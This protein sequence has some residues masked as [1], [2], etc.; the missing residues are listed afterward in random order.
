MRLVSHP[1]QKLVRVKK[2]QTSPLKMA[3]AKIQ[4]SEQYFSLTD[5][6]VAQEKRNFLS[7][8]TVTLDRSI[9]LSHILLG[10]KQDDGRV[11]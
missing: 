3:E 6:L 4:E 5:E 11:I 9:L 2:H 1:E 10:S 8:M 7:V